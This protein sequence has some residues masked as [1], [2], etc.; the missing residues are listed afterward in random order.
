MDKKIYTDAVS[1]CIDIRNDMYEF[2][3]KFFG[4]SDQLREYEIRTLLKNTN[5]LLI[6]VTKAKLPYFGELVSLLVELSIIAAYPITDGIRGEAIKALCGELVKA[7]II[8]ECAFTD[9]VGILSDEGIYSNDSGELIFD[10]NECDMTAAE[11]YVQ[12][13]LEG[14]Y[15][16]DLP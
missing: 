8:S 9:G 5:D 15:W 11:Q 3:E 1:K 16:F 13:N 10:F 2:K 4:G 7:A 14:V 6:E 12:K